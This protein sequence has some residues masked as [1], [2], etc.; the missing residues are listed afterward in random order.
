MQTDDA[1]ETELTPAAADAAA[2]SVRDVE[3]EPWDYDGFVE[4]YN[5]IVLKRGGWYYEADGRTP[6][7]MRQRYLR[8]PETFTDLHAF[9]EGL[10]IWDQGLNL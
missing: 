8:S 7:E 5:R 9:A 6:E 1:K 2:G 3:Q 10:V 4:A